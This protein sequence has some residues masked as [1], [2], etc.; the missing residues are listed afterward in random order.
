MR[1]SIEIEGGSL[2]YSYFFNNYDDSNDT[3]FEDSGTSNSH[4]LIVIDCV[5]FFVLNWQP[6][7]FT[8]GVPRMSV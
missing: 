7:P 5:G 1:K 4:F 8:I 6:W 3:F 2:R